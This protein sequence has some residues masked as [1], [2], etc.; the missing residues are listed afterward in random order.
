MQLERHEEKFPVV[1]MVQ[2]EHKAQIASIEVGFWN[3]WAR[4]AKLGIGGD[5]DFEA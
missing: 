5:R 2:E 3:F 1:E 4:L